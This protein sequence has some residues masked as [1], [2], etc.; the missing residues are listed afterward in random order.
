M[1][2][3]G[4]KTPERFSW[5]LVLRDL[6]VFMIFP[7]QHSLLARIP[8]KEWIQRHLDP[9]MERPFY[10]G[11]SG[12]AMWFIVLFWQPFGPVLFQ[13]QN[14]ILLDI[15][16]YAAL[17][18]IILSTVALEHATMFGL[19]QGY[20]AW[21]R[22]ASSERTELRTKGIY[23]IV[24]HPITSLLIVALWSHPVLFADRLLFNFLFSAYALIGTVF[25]EKDLK[26]AFGDD[27]RRYAREVPA[28]IP[29]F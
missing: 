3:F 27:Y 24:R 17:L 20:D 7:L 1:V 9:K 12:L 8:W 13:L 5:A 15:I 2:Q 22:P 28:F 21:K 16:F 18:S 6:L 23:G 29:R 25:E 26:K 11:T 19:K 10:V 4:F 14:W